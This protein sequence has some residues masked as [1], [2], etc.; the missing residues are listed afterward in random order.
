MFSAQGI[1]YYSYLAGIKQIDDSIN[2]QNINIDPYTNEFTTSC[3]ISSISASVNTYQLQGELK[4][5]WIT[6]VN[7]DNT[8]EYLQ[9]NVTMPSRS[10]TNGI[11][12]KNGSLSIHKWIV[13]EMDKI[14]WSNMKFSN[15][16]KG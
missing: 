4:I 6:D 15:E 1:Q 13:Q 16:I 12:I 11:M 2:W 7:K 3:G 10:I 14:V 5:L 9:M 8:K